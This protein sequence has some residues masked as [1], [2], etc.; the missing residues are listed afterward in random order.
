M[1]ENKEPTLTE[2]MAE[3]KRSNLELRKEIERSR[4]AMWLTPTAFGGSVALFGVS[5]LGKLPTTTW[6]IW[7][8]GIGIMLLGFIFMQWVTNK[9]K[10]AKQTFES[11][12][13]ESVKL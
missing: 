12:W 8:S 5:V 2:I 10:K 4:M 13:N 11:K 6:G 3:L 9:Q 7:V 1:S